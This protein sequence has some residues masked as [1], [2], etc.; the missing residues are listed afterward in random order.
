MTEQ[1][2]PL[3]ISSS[4]ALIDEV[5]RL[6]SSAALEVHVAS[7]I[8][9]ASTHWFT[10]PLVI[11]G[12]DAIVEEIP[13][14]RA[15]VIV[16]H[17]SPTNSV[18][19]EETGALDTA[20]QRDIWRFA[21][22]LGAEHVVEL[23]DGERWLL[24]A[25][26]ECAEGPVR[27]GVVVPVLSGSGGA[28]AS[29]LSANLAVVGS[30]QGSRSLVIDADPWGGGIDLLMGAEEATGARWSDL[31]N[32]SGHLPAGHLDAA[33]P[34]IADVSILS[35]AR[36]GTGIEHGP[37]VETMAAV[38]SS[39]RRSHD[40]VL[41]DCPRVHDEIL[42][43]V[44]E[45]ASAAVL[46]VGDHVRPTAAAARRYAW[47][48]AR[49]PRVVLVQANTPRGINSD[50]ISHALG[51]EFLATLPF[52]PSMTTRADEGELP[53]LPH[54]YAQACRLILEEIGGSTD[55]LRAA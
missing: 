12:S 52:V 13:G 34:K 14:R 48:R 50:D 28:G 42:S 47:L 2:R 49:V 51:A 10:A 43:V 24:D 1:D 25:F 33:L 8:G 32:V 53:A 16:V 26:R 15:R 38:L 55:R 44:L 18:D 27:N 3:L 37:T 19:T 23:P 41:V 29:T 35:C 54:A 11:V 39:A 6:A 31:R 21:V 5:V 30:Q 36:E 40:L 45:Q 20:T 7:D 17:G 46:I 9:S 4:L 22:E